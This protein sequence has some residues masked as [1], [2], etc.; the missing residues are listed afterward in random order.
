[1]GAD[2][3]AKTGWHGADAGHWLLVR[4]SKIVPGRAPEGRLNCDAD[5]CQLH[6]PRAAETPDAAEQAEAAQQHRPRRGLGDGLHHLETV[7]LSRGQG[8]NDCGVFLAP[9]GFWRSRKA[10]IPAKVQPHVLTSPRPKMR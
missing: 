5:A 6:L 8:C 9:F 7:D 4:A 2:F 10:A 1:M 3:P